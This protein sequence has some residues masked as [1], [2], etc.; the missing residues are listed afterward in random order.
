MLRQIVPGRQKPRH[1]SLTTASEKLYHDFGI[2]PPGL[3]S[4][5]NVYSLYCRAVSLAFIPLTILT[6]KFLSKRYKNRIRNVILN[7]NNCYNICTVSQD[8]NDDFRLNSQANGQMTIKN[9]VE[10]CNICYIYLTVSQD[11]VKVTFF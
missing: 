3:L 9:A 8:S 11:Y 5:S 7:C 6:V 4:L 1:A 10:N 2:L